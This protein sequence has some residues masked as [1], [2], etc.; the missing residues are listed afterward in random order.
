MFKIIFYLIVNLISLQ[1]FASSEL[2]ITCINEAQTIVMEYNANDVSTQIN[3]FE[4]DILVFTD[5]F[6]V[7][8]LNEPLF[9]GADPIEQWHFLNE[10]AGSIS[11]GAISESEGKADAFIEMGSAGVFD[12]NTL[13][14][15]LLRK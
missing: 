4:N 15:T 11:V 12:G 1:A 8:Y 5:T 3:V 2:S 7:L 10:T 6:D 13:D 14:C 9:A